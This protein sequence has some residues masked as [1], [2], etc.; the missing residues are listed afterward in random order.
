MNLISLLKHIFYKIHF[1]SVI[2]GLDNKLVFYQSVLFV[3]ANE[4]IV[5]YILYGL[6]SIGTLLFYLVI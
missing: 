4:I 1:S 6:A 2:S 5:T 3:I